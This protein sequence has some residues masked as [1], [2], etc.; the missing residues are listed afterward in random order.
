[1]GYTNGNNVIF[2]GVDGNYP[3]RVSAAVNPPNVTFV[4]SGYTL[5]NDTPQTV[6]LSSA[7]T[8]VPKLVVAA[9]KTATIG[10]NVTVNNSSTS[11]FGN[12]GDTWAEPS[13]SK[14][15]AL[16]RSLLE[17]HSSWMVRGRSSA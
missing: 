9:G 13:S 3:I 15:A 17:T 10:T 16:S 5:T 11:F 2:G 6:T 4:N 1:M 7:S 12:A 14:T 8:G